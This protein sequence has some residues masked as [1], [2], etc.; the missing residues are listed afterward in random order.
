MLCGPSGRR[1]QVQVRSR[2]DAH[3]DTAPPALRRDPAQLGVWGIPV[4]TRV[5]GVAVASETRC[6]PFCRARIQQEAGL[7]HPIWIDEWKDGTYRAPGASFQSARPS[8]TCQYSEAHFDKIYH[9]LV[10]I[11]RGCVD[12]SV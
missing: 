9:P 6:T 8:S 11:S 3:L 4:R 2:N 12:R 1:D 10:L 7:L 5:E